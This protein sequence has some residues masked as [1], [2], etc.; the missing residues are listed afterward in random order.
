MNKLTAAT[1]V[2]AL[3]FVAKPIANP[4]GLND[5]IENQ[6]YS[7]QLQLL[8]ANDAPLVGAVLFDTSPS[9]ENT[10]QVEHIMDQVQRQFVPAV[11]MIQA[12]DTV[13]FPNSDSIRHHVFS[14]STARSFDL[15]LYGNSTAPTID[16]PNAGYIVVGC[17]IHD[18]MIGHI[19]VSSSGQFYESDKAGNIDVSM[20]DVF[21][22]W[23]LWHPW[24]AAAG[25]APIALTEIALTE[26]FRLAIEAPPAREESELE[27]RFRRRLQ[28]GH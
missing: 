12:G 11:L 9:A 20:L 23:Y 10:A 16:F 25:L 27:S 8:D 17:N 13:K 5:Q 22:G 18:D 15:E 2:L 6:K 4:I 1:L 24:M 21:D 14:F 19:I 3:F 7:S 28:R 26:P